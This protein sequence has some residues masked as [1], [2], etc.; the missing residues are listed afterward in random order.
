VER[1]VNEEERS[2]TVM[3]MSEG[4]RVT[5]DRPKGGAAVCERL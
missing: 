1:R 2:R 4:K 3:K 5:S